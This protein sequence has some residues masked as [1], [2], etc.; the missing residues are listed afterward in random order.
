[1]AQKASER[2]AR[3]GYRNVECRR[4]DGYEG[5]PEQAPFDGIL[6]TAAAP[7]VPPPLIEQ[8]GEGARLIVPVGPQYGPQELQ[9]IEKRADGSVH[10]TDVL[11][12]AFVPLTRPRFRSEELRQKRGE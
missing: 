10:T 9:A 1:L 6:V 4:C 3:L 8:L 2:L 12:V 5:W 7:A 11:G